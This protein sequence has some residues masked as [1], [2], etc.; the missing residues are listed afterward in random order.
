MTSLSN[1]FLSP[2]ANQ[3]PGAP[4]HVLCLFDP[5][6]P[7]P[8]SYTPRHDRGLGSRAPPLHTVAHSIASRP[9]S[10]PLLLVLEHL[11][12][13]RPWRLHPCGTIHGCLRAIHHELRWLV[14]RRRPCV[15][16]TR[17]SAPRTHCTRR[18]SPHP[19]HPR[20][21]PCQRAPRRTW[22]GARCTCHLQRSTPLLWAAW[23]SHRHLQP[24][25]ARRHGAGAWQQA[26]AR[27]VVFCLVGEHQ[28]GAADLRAL[29]MARCAKPRTSSHAAAS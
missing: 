10:G 19:L 14:R 6:F 21:S 4:R 5:L 8:L 17:S 15:A 2:L 7:W 13:S 3:N 11:R 26:S 24:R 16:I 18:L 20:G 25:H 29:A 27:Q 9:R 22:P 28:H 1:K 12:R 23:R